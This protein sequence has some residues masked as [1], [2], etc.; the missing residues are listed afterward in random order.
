MALC[1]VCSIIEG[2]TDI[3]DEGEKLHKIECGANADQESKDAQEDWLR[4]MSFRRHFEVVKRDCQEGECHFRTT[5]IHVVQLLTF[6]NASVK[7]R[8][9]YVLSSKIL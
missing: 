1:Q 5:K 8:A 4:N 6:V 3:A 7:T 9:Q 2:V